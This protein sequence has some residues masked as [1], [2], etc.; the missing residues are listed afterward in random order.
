[1]VFHEQ[2]LED[3]RRTSRLTS[4]EADAGS[5]GRWDPQ[6]QDITAGTAPAQGA[7]LHEATVTDGI[8]SGAGV[9][10]AFPSLPVRTPRPRAADLPLA[11]LKTHHPAALPGRGAWPT[12]R[13]CTQTPDP[14]DARNLG[15]AVPA[16]ASTASKDTFVRHLDGAVRS[17]TGPASRSARGSA[18][19][20]TH[21]S[22]RSSGSSRGRG[23]PD[24]RRPSVADSLA[25]LM[26]LA[27]R[28]ARVVGE[29]SPRR[30]F[31]PLRLA[32]G[33]W[34]RRRDRLGDS[35]RPAL[36]GFELD[37][38]S[39]RSARARGRADGPVGAPPLGDAVT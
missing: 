10:F 25:G 35:P 30:G 31:R 39:G 9:S 29:S 24:H 12:T 22:P 27:G 20:H 5:L 28:A 15:I 4:N 11:W 19:H 3:R 16:W 6:D 38:W 2:V 8:W 13:G 1:M 18:R 34:S 37:R 21:C 36:P 17:P 26:A 23:R 7:D 32:P 33:C 14:D